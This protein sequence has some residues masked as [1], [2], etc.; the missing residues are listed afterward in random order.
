[1]TIYAL[2]TGPGVSGVAI[3]RIS[4]EQ[5]SKVIKT[6]TGKKVPQPRVATLRKINK[7]NTS[8]LIDEGIILWFPGPESYTGEDMAEIQVHGSKAVVDAL[9]SS[10]SQIE[11]CRLAE[12]GEFTKLAFQN[13]KINL[14]EAESIADLISSETEIQ[15]QQAIKIMNGKSADQFNFLREKLLKILSHVEAKIDF[16]DEDLPNNILDEI[17]NDSNDVIQK[18]E[19]ILNDQK[20]GERIREG[21]KIAILGPTNAGK[22]SLIN[23][24]SNRDVAIVSE[25]A[26]TTRDVIETHLNIDGYPVIISDTAGIRES[27]DEIEKKGIKLSLNRAEE[28]DLKLVV[29]DAKSLDFSDVLKGL[30]DENAILVINKSDLLEKEI[31]SEI[32]NINHVLISIKDNKNIDELISKIKNNLKNKFITSDDILITRERHRQHLEQ[33]LDHLNNFNQKKEIEDFDKASEDLRLA[34]R[35]LGMIVGK[36]DVEEILG[37]IFNDFCIG[38]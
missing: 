37:S 8:E 19:K 34:T 11:N 7:I 3:V 22:S 2:S 24:L 30:L 27:K 14:L 18:I 4:G 26:G 5:S 15:R 13:G 25:I 23:H 38:K 21:F 16:P 6:L 10:I 29:V 1:M 36:V 31:D 9:H 12:P 33:C 20:V 17:K 28:A 32:K 35:H